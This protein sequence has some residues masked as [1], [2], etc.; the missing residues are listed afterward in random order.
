MYRLDPALKL[1]SK[2]EFAIRS[3]AGFMETM[4][5]SKIKPTARHHDS[6]EPELTYDGSYPVAVL[7]GECALCTFGARLISIV[8]RRQ[9][10]KICPV[11][12]DLGSALL[13]HYGIEP[14]DPESWLFIVDGRGWTSFDA[15]IKAGEACGGLGNL[16]RLFWIVPKPV[17]DWIYCWVARNRI[18][19]FGRADICSVPDARLRAR[20]IGI[21]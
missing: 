18:A 17:R 10:I 4:P 20:L 2:L 7:D 14:T 19:L 5:E 15:W 12:T 3:G 1:C 9:R 21:P 16:M 8:D 11:Q 13:R 6:K